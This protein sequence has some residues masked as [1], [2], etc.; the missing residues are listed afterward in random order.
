MWLRD[1]P[2]VVAACV[3][4]LLALITFCHVARWT[5]DAAVAWRA[6]DYPWVGAA[7]GTIVITTANLQLAAQRSEISA[8]R[9]DIQVSGSALVRSIDQ[10]HSFCNKI[11]T[12]IQG[13]Q[14]G[15]PSSDTTILFQRRKDYG[16][17]FGCQN[18]PLL[19]DDI[20]D[21][22]SLPN[23][24]MRRPWIHGYLGLIC[25]GTLQIQGV[26]KTDYDRVLVAKM[27]DLTTSSRDEICTSA[28][29]LDH[30]GQQFLDSDKR[31][32][33][34]TSNPLV[35]RIA[36]SHGLFWW[37]MALAYAAGLRLGKV[38]AEILQERR[39]RKQEQRRRTPMAS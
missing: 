14:N 1:Q 36:S 15:T 33:S 5:Y 7:V 22:I 17:A 38:H 11:E 12:V 3:S 34:L 29:S 37:Y 10:L 28:Y 35:G 21:Q 13:K 16:S 31:L 26:P 39:R 2:L 25:D 9:S 18:I 6:V 20:K 30:V 8:L 27:Q 32:A 24:P 19:R 23:W 4:F